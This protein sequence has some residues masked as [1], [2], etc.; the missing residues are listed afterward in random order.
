MGKYEIELKTV[1]ESMG[2]YLN[3]RYLS[4]GYSFRLMF[5]L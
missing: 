4:L 1:S 5:F 3:L 2:L